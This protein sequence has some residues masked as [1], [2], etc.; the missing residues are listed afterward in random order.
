VVL[1]APGCASL[2]Q[3]RSYEERG[4]RFAAAA[5]ALPGAEALR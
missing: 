3:F 2:D 1:L 5:R 4:A